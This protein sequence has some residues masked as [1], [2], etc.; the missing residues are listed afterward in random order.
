MYIYWEELAC[1]HLEKIPDSEGWHLYCDCDEQGKSCLYLQIGDK[2]HC[3]CDSDFIIEGHPKLF[4]YDAE[5][6]FSAVVNAVSKLVAHN[7]PRYIDLEEIQEQVINPIWNSWKKGGL[8][9]AED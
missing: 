3:I 8:V 1:A 9:E 6:C 4:D 7:T 2:V 5:F